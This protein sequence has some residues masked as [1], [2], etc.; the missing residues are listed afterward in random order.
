MLIFLST[1]LKTKAPILFTGR[2]RVGE[3]VNRFLFYG[4]LIDCWFVKKYQYAP[5]QDY[6]YFRVPK[7]YLPAYFVQYSQG[8]GEIGNY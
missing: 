8:M 2:R 3:F 1:L 6:G 7:Y 4:I 5:G